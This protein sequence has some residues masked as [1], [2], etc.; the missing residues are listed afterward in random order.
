[1]RFST[2]LVTLVSICAL[3]TAGCGSPRSTAEQV[4]Q[5]L[6]EFRLAVDAPGVTV[7][8][9]RPDAAD[10]VAG[11]GDERV[12]AHGRFLIASVTMTFV[13]AVVH[14]LV[15]EGDLALDDTID[16][17]VPDVP[18]AQ[19]ITVRQILS[20]TSGLTDDVDAPVWR[21]ELLA[22]PAA[23]YD[24]GAALRIARPQAAH[25]P[26]H[27]E[28]AYA[29]Y[30][31][32][33]VIVEAISK[34][35][36]AEELARRFWRPLGM[37]ATSLNPDDAGRDLVAG[38]FTL[39]DNSWGQAQESFDRGV[40]RD[41]NV[42]TFEALPAVQSAVGAAGGVVSSWS[43]LLTW[44][45]ALADGRALGDAT[46]TMFY[47]PFPIA[48]GPNTKTGWGLGIL[49][50]ACPCDLDA[51]PPQAMFSFHHGETIGSRTM[52]AIDPSTRTVIVIHA[53]VREVTDDA[54]LE[55]A[56]EVHRLVTR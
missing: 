23:R 35:P 32:A 4:G 6:D 55:L 39:E 9:R 48:D 42:A 13:A 8:V 26:G 49:A 36:L 53:N 1:M 52:L 2:P 17:W 20:H 28:Y 25:E 31:I 12:T 7:A 24:T 10:L 45:S 50:H 30:L 38:W 54:L 14:S 51:A 37:D 27:Y 15:S 3:A 40:R 11:S 21:A 16:A 46:T 18:N 5:A 47:G 29:N 41:R 22:D 43:D 44:G 33:G 19:R 56:S 34:R